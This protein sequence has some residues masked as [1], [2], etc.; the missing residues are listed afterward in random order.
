MSKPASR[1][2]AEAIRELTPSDADGGVGSRHRAPRP[3]A[4]RSGTVE[5]LRCGEAFDSWDK[6]RNRICARCSSRIN[7][8]GAGLDAR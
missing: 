6:R 2:E 4:S 8:D 7:R 1:S 3:H 5:C